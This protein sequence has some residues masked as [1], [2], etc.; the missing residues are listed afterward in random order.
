MIRGINRSI[1]EIGDTENEY[2]ERAILV[3]RPEYASAER[4]VLEDEARK[5][6]RRMDA[7]SVFRSR[8]RPFVRMFVFGAV[9]LAGVAAAAAII[10]LR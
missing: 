2:Y 8:R 10:G 6:L 7:P 9:F 5:L 1:I 4:A 3:V